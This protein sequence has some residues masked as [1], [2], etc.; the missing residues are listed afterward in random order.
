MRFCSL[1]GLLFALALSTPI[2]AA[3]SCAHCDA[4]SDWFEKLGC[5]ERCLSGDDADSTETPDRQDQERI[6]R[7]PPDDDTQACKT[8][9]TGAMSAL[10][11]RLFDHA[12]DRNFAYTWLSPYPY[13]DLG[14]YL[15]DEDGTTPLIRTGYETALYRRLKH[16]LVNREVFDRL[17]PLQLF[18]E[19]IEAIL[20]VRDL[21][22]SPGGH[23]YINIVDV[24]LTAHNVTRIVARPEQWISDYPKTPIGQYRPSEDYAASIFTDLLGPDSADGYPSLYTYFRWGAV[25]PRQITEVFYGRPGVFQFFAEANRVD[26]N[27]L[28]SHWNGGIHYYFWIGATGRWLGDSMTAGYY[29][30]Y[31]PEVAGFT[32]YLK[33]GMA[34]YQ[35]ASI[36]IGMGLR[37]GSFFAGD[38]FKAI[39]KMQSALPSMVQ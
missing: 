18:F 28:P 15:M 7:T 32:E 5:V 1:L 6:V 38:V 35:R 4:I 14:F 31:G 17:T 20:D 36:Q 19:S 34:E 10:E 3:D 39:E 23:M 26:D 33:K 27:Y 12:C 37:Q 29:G 22:M 24:F 30:F 2:R 9:Y 11:K 21:G 25:L 13:V 8:T 16:R